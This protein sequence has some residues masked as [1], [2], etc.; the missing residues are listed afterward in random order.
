MTYSNIDTFVISLIITNFSQIR[1]YHLSAPTL[2]EVLSMS[3]HFCGK[4]TK[5]LQTLPPDPAL[6][7]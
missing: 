2:N 6:S 3:V 1:P 4:L 7:C 5:F